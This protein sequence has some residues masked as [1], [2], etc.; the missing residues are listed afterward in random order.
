[1]WLFEKIEQIG[2][3]FFQRD[4]QDKSIIRNEKNV[5]KLITE[6][7][8]LEYLE[9]RKN[10]IIEKE[11]RFSVTEEDILKYLDEERIKDGAERKREISVKTIKTSDNGENPNLEQKGRNYAIS[12]IHG[13]YG[14][15]MDVIGGLEEKDTLYVIGDVVDRGKNGISILQDMMKRK[16][17][18]FILGNHEWQMIQVL[19]L[20]KKYN[21]DEKDIVNYCKAGEEAYYERINRQDPE[22]AEQCRK[23][24]EDILKQVKDKKLYEDDMILMYIWM[25]ENLGVYTLDEYLQLPQKQQEDIYNYLTDAYVLAKKQ[26]GEEKI[27]LVHASPPEADYLIKNA[28]NKPEG[29]IR[30]SSLVKNTDRKYSET[31]LAI[32]TETRN[33][34]E[35]FEFW[36]GHGY[37]TIYGHTPSRGHIKNNIKNNA[38]CIDAGCAYK[39]KLALYCLEDGK[40]KYIEPKEDFVNKEDNYRE[41]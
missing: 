30:Y 3:L 7:D 18:K 40:V 4:E 1:M 28:D 25:L 35:G 2:K 12:D 22:I 36:R 38:V 14:S 34:N 37:K 8:I 31:F 24:K 39:G 33:K 27:L 17:V 32:C 41:L 10:P 23:N 19:D 16:N 13:M 11:E 6:E 15:Y 29:G 21:L 5:N 20:I 26:V 9:E